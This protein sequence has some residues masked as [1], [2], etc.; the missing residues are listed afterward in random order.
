MGDR[1]LLFDSCTK[2]FHGAP[3]VHQMFL[4]LFHTSICMYVLFAAICDIDDGN[5]DGNRRQKSNDISALFKGAQHIVTN[6]RA[7]ERTTR[8]ADMWIIRWAAVAKRK[9]SWHRVHICFGFRL[10]FYEQ[11]FD[12]RS[13]GNRN[14]RHNTLVATH[15]H[16]HKTTA[17]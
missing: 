2:Q 17:K 3:R 4:W 10:D 9:N 5:D 1:T 13:I 15:T 8:P 6:E 11:H 7:N 16:T 12:G 14:D